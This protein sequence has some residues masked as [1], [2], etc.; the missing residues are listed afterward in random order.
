MLL[1]I[2]G[3]AFL[4]TG[5]TSRQKKLWGF[6]LGCLLFSTLIVLP[7]CGGGVRRVPDYCSLCLLACL[8]LFSRCRSRLKHPPSRLS[9]RSTLHPE[10]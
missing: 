6:L 2:G 1:P 4:G 10:S 3:L 8:R 7:A 5:I 9:A